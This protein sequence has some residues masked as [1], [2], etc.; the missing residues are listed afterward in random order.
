LDIARDPDIVN[1]PDVKDF[2]NGKYGWSYMT[3]PREEY[4]SVTRGLIH[5]NTWKQAEGAYK[6]LNE[7]E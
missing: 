1:A 4:F 6:Y 3:C 2:D 5:F 7:E